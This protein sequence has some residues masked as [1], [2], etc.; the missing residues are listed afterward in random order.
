VET[1]P[2]ANLSAIESINSEEEVVLVEVVVLVLVMLLL[3][4]VVVAVFMV[5]DEVHTVTRTTV[6]KVDNDG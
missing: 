3:A 5:L 2:A 4:A 1:V 6:D